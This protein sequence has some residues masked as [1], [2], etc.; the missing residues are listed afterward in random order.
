M[1]TLLLTLTL[2]GCAAAA[3]YQAPQYPVG[4]SALT[5]YDMNGDPYPTTVTEQCACGR[6]PIEA[7]TL[8]SG[9]PAPEILG[10]HKPGTGAELP[11][12]RQGCEA[13]PSDVGQPF[14]I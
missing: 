2:I 1:R 5:S 12:C 9:D 11:R 6:E 8:Y 7:D 10:G 4:Y 3:P 14:S 13:P